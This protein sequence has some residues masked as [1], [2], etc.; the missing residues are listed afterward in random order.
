MGLSK[1]VDFGDVWAKDAPGLPL[2]L[3]LDLVRRDLGLEL[4]VRISGLLRESIAHA[5]A[6]EEDALTYAL[7]Y[8]RGID[9][10]TGRKFVRMYVNEDTL[11]MG[12]PGVAAL[13]H[14]YARAKAKGLLE[15]IPPI[16]LV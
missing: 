7:G 2:P 8:G 5:L 3:G 11:D 16:D 9:R 4:A 14:L 10:D 15:A 1:I 13:R 12:E 6:H